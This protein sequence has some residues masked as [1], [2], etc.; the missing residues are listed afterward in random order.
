[1]TPPRISF[2]TGE[3]LQSQTSKGF[4]RILGMF[5]DRAT[6]GQ[7]LGPFMFPAFRDS[8]GL[9]F[10]DVEGSGF[11]EVLPPKALR[12]HILRYFRPKDHDRGLWG[13]FEP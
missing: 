9:G 10:G 11:L 3:A 6:L 4:K 12:T 1:M 5:R 7:G 13:D 8:S 2:Q